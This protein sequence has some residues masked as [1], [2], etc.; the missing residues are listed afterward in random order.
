LAIGILRFSKR[1]STANGISDG[2]EST[3]QMKV[4]AEAVKI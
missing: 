4:I 1:V 2:D 3:Q